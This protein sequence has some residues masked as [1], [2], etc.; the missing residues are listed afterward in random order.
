MIKKK[1]KCYEKTDRTAFVFCYGAVFDRLFLAE[2][3]LR[4]H[5]ANAN[6]NAKAYTYQKRFSDEDWTIME[7]ITMEYGI[8]DEDWDIIFLQHSAEGAAQADTYKDYIPKLIT[9]IDSKKTNPNARYVWN[10][11]WAFPGDSSNKLFQ[12]LGA[13]Q[14]KHYE[15]IVAATQEHV[16]PVEEF[17]AIIFINKFRFVELFIAACTN[18][19]SRGEGGRANARSDVE[20]GR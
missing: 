3:T 1:E 10:M 4:T 2:C 17:A 5:V 6:G 13:D 7:S 16:I 14:I 11:T 9:Y 19:F 20:C 8:Q 12:S 18:A 15:T